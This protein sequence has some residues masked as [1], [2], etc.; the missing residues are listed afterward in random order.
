MK[1]TSKPTPSS[2]LQ[3]REALRQCS[4]AADLDE[5]MGEAVDSSSWQQALRLLDHAK[6]ASNPEPDSLC[7]STAMAVCAK[8]GQWASVLQLLAELKGEGT[9]PSTK[10]PGAALRPGPARASSQTRTATGAPGQ[11]D[12]DEM[13]GGLEASLQGCTS[14]WRQALELLAGSQAAPGEP[15]S[16]SAPKPL[17]PTAPADVLG[18]SDA[19]EGKCKN[20]DWHE[21]LDLLESLRRLVPLQGPEKQDLF[22]RLDVNQDG[23]IDR[24]ELRR[25][26]REGV[27]TSGDNLQ[28]LSALPTYGQERNGGYQR[29]F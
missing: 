18:L 11:P 15:S 10:L 26:I 8:G 4:E 25:G 5:E 14:F 29:H 21:A 17:S 2:I 22:A 19:I 13:L 3:C 27:I 28:L 1:A 20:G 12:V 24:E 9:A 6:T 23:V 16:P 7:Y